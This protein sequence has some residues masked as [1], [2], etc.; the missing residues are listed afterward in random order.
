LQQVQ[1]SHSQTEVVKNVLFTPTRASMELVSREL[2]SGFESG[3]YRFASFYTDLSTNK[4][5]APFSIK[6]SLIS[7]PVFSY[8]ANYEPDIIQ[9]HTPI[10]YDV[11]RSNNL[12]FVSGKQTTSKHV[13]F[14]KSLCKTLKGF[15]IGFIFF[16]YKQNECLL[17]ACLYLQGFINIE[18]FLEYTLIV[19]G[20]N[21][22]GKT[23]DKLKF[24]D[25]KKQLY[26]EIRPLLEFVSACYAND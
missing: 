6:R 12:E 19:S 23:I 3:F 22:P 20:Q 13:S 4:K 9:S 24:K 14:V 11:F 5:R 25:L 1:Q 18:E 17:L 7:D 16:I 26:L 21:L 8:F 10:L 15:E 2:Q